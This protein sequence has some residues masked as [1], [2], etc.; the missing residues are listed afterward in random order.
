[1]KRQIL[2][3]VPL[4]AIAVL[5]LL[6]SAGNAT[7]PDETTGTGIPALGPTTQDSCNA[8]SDACSAADL[9]FPGGTSGFN[10]APSVQCPQQNRCHAA[11]DCPDFHPIGCVWLCVQKC[12]EL[13]C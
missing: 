3:A 8:A 9:P 5:A 7:V 2:K 10:P 6:V 4:V 1:M 11:T 12:C 13:D